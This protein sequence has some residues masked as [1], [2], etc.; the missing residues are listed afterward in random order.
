MTIP[1]NKSLSILIDTA[2]N[3]LL[4][5]NEPD[6]TD[7]FVFLKER[8]YT[9]FQ[10]GGSKFSAEELDRAQ[11]LILGVPENTYLLQEEV[12]LIMDFVRSGG[13]LLI[14]HRYGG[15]LV[16]KTDLNE[17]SAQ[18]GIYFENT[19]IRDTTNVGV[20]CV[21]VITIATTTPILKGINKIVLAGACSLRVAKDAKPLVMANPTSSLELFNPNTYS[22]IKDDTHESF[23]L[24][25]YTTYGQGRVVAIGS[26]EFLFNMS[27]FGFSSLD[28][29]KFTQNI[30][31][32]L[33]QPVSETEVKEWMLAQIGTITEH[34]NNFKFMIT[35]L[36]N[37][38]EALEHRMSDLEHKYYASKGI[39]LPQVDEEK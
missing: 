3:N 28:N 37:S 15:D 7:F 20:D 34:F 22:W 24:A 13:A 38:L 18:F 23:C 11:V 16:Q 33:A 25:A 6:Y 1:W 19:L 10:P 17:L 21:P 5:P 12:V 32:W 4:H 29:K 26:P 30:F 31:N 2:H 14:M 27:T 9:V 35:K 36:T 39:H 8:G